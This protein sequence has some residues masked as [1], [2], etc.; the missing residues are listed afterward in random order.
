MLDTGQLRFLGPYLLV[1]VLF[2]VV[3]ALP[4]NAM[5]QDFEKSEQEEKFSMATETQMPWEVSSDRAEGSERGPGLVASPNRLSPEQEYAGE[6]LS[7]LVKVVIGQ[8]G[9]PRSREEWRRT[10]LDESL[11]SERFYRAVG[12]PEEDV[13]VLVLPDPNVLD[14]SLVLYN[15]DPRLS[16]TKGQFGIVGIYPAPE[17]MAFRLLLLQKIDRGEKIHLKAL[18]ERKALLFDRKRDPSER[19]YE[20]TN[21]RPDELRLLRDIIAKEPRVYD[22]M[23][24]PFL[25]KALYEVAAVERDDFV[26][27]RM[28]EARY[29]RYRCR[30][31]SGSERPEAV[32]IAIL[33]SIIQ[34]FKYVKSLDHSSGSGFEATGFFHEMVGRLRDQ[35]LAEAGAHLNRKINEG[36]SAQDRVMG[37]DWERRWE[38]I[39]REKIAFYVQDQ[40]PLVIYPANAREV[41]QDVCPEADFVVILLGQRV[42]LALY[43]TEQDVYPFVNRIYMDISDIKYSQIQA[44][45]EQLA[46]VIS[47]RIGDEV[48]ASIRKIH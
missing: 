33:P 10:G 23:T 22:Y 5:G 21:L 27:K 31:F 16:S 30:L 19:D 1:L 9:N 6:I 36:K 48:E 28:A 13:Y 12:N 43:I 17:V 42:Y 40:R 35:I 8:E 20:A 37:A 26:E 7:Y 14:I 18:V 39:A 44:E 25:V 3:G 47:S 2:M 46:D 11:E 41:I 38:G 4:G 32:R 24:S 29:E 34:T 15:Y 45:C